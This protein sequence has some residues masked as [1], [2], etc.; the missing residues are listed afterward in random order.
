ML[1]KISQTDKPCMIL[2]TC[3]LSKSQTHRKTDQI[4]GFQGFVEG[5]NGE[6]LVKIY[7][8]PFIR[9]ITS[10]YL[11]YSMMTIINNTVLYTWKCLKEQVLHIFNAHTHTEQSSEVMYLLTNLIVVTILQSIGVSN[12]HVLHLI[13][14]YMS[15]IS[16]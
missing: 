4:G 2:L 16:Q 12:H 13:C 1:S 14:Y 15:S 6:M 7:K 9:L 10:R 5:R 3:G 11:M 8:F